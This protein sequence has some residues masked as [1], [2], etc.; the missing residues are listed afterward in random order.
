MSIF[1]LYFYDN[2]LSI[3]NGYKYTL[4][5]RW[6]MIFRRT[7][8]QKHKINITCKKRL[9]IFYRR[10]ILKPAIKYNKNREEL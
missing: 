8:L 2:C 10:V 6:K 4:E 3:D 1:K 9:K 7:L 5:A